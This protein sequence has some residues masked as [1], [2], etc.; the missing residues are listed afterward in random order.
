MGECGGELLDEMG[1]VAGLLQL[2]D[3]GD[4]NVIVDGG[5]VDGVRQG[6]VAGGRWRSAFAI[7]SGVF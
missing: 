3:D 2:L 1:P 5:G 6:A 7:S 4:N